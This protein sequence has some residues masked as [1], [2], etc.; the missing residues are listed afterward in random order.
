MWA[1]DGDGCR[2][3]NNGSCRIVFGKEV[4]IV[5]VSTSKAAR[6]LLS[7]SINIQETAIFVGIVAHFLGLAVA[8]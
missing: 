6:T 8:S 5:F 3:S 4:G 1:I 2:A 7:R